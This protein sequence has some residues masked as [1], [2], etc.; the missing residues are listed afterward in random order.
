MIILSIFCHL[1]PIDIHHCVKAT[2]NYPVVNRE[3][4]KQRTEICEN[5]ALK[6]DSTFTKLKHYTGL[7]MPLSQLL[8]FFCEAS[9]D[10]NNFTGPQVSC[11]AHLQL[12]LRV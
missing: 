6:Y 11:K 3:H 2:Q 8:S 1:P 5:F 12:F 7:A 10:R 4:T 9:I